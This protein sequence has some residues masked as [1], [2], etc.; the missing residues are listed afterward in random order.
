MS[1]WLAQRLP[2]NDAAYVFGTD[3]RRPVG[4]TPRGL[5]HVE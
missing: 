2:S 5:V 1:C 4:L 3:D